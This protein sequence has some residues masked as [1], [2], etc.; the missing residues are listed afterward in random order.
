[1]AP[2][3]LATALC[4]HKIRLSDETI[5]VG[6]TVAKAE[7]GRDGMAKG[8]YSQVRGGSLLG[9]ALFL[10]RLSCCCSLERLS[11]GSLTAL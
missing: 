5:V 8:L 4:T 3:A 11:D 9:T 10:E 6:L 2:G 1:V 7:D